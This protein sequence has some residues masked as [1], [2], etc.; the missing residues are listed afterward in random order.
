MPARGRRL[1][2]VLAVDDDIV[3]GRA[4]SC[5]RA[6]DS[7]DIAQQRCGTR[8]S[9]PGCGLPDARLTCRP[10]YLV[11][12]ED[13]MDTD[14]ELFA[15]VQSRWPSSP[16]TANSQRQQRNTSDPRCHRTKRKGVASRRAALGGCSGRM[17][18]LVLSAQCSPARG[19]GSL[20]RDRLAICF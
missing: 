17:T 8:H 2:L 16:R 1:G 7:D 5:R 3:S 10:E 4:K 15:A 6:P 9:V 13:A 19:G 11:H 18:T 12:S 20:A 14:T